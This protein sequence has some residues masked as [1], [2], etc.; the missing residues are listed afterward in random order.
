[1]NKFLILALLCLIYFLGPT[2]SFSHSGNTDS[3]GGHYNRSTGEYHYHNEKYNYN[4]KDN[5]KSEEEYDYS[6][7][8][9][10][11]VEDAENKT[12]KNQAYIL[13]FYDKAST[14][15]QFELVSQCEK[16]YND[17]YDYSQESDYLIYRIIFGLLIVFGPGFYIMREMN[18][19]TKY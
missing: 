15:K 5:E 19:L 3:N 2:V 17:G 11:G 1:M 10:L 18:K 13:S 8:Y 12:R 7:C 6:K 16:N 4:D 14:N 9:E